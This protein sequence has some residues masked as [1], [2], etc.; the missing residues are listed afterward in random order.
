MSAPETNPPLASFQ[1]FLDHGFT[2][3]ST[4]HD[5][6]DICLNNFTNNDPAVQILK[7]S[8]CRHIFGRECIL[9]WLAA[10]NSCPLCRAVL[11]Q[12][13]ASAPSHIHRQAR[14]HGGWL[15]NAFSETFNPRPTSTGDLVGM[16]CVDVSVI[17][18]TGIDWNQERAYRRQV[19]D[20]HRRRMAL[21]AERPYGGR[22]EPV[23]PRRIDL[24]RRVQEAV[25]REE[26]EQHPAEAQS[27]EAMDGSASEGIGEVYDAPKKHVAWE[28]DDGT[29]DAKTGETL[30]SDAM[31]D[32]D[33]ETPDIVKAFDELL[34]PDTEVNKI[35]Q[36]KE[37]GNV[38]A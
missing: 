21:E 35:I 18:E 6:C 15:V 10:H 4:T 7:I 13:S 38:E 5:L 22:N 9:V 37:G 31:E 1:D 14:V 30:E 28:M 8:G 19:R 26:R 17:L 29:K 23:E 12:P 2:E 11:I 27:I 16:Q 36:A 24:G 34:E 32:K 25:T 3:V 33:V 20:Q